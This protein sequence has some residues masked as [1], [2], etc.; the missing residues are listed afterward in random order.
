MSIPFMIPVAGGLVKLKPVISL[1]ELDGVYVPPPLEGY[2]GDVPPP[3]EPPEGLVQAA[4]S[5][6]RTRAGMKKLLR[7]R[8]GGGK[9]SFTGHK[10]KGSFIIT[11]SLHD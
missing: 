11:H 9:N 5:M 8:A 2:S 10:K 7:I 1:A 3:S 6:Q 4:R